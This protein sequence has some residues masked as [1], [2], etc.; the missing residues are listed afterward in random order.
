MSEPPVEHG[1][2]HQAC[3]SLPQRA[4]RAHHA[5]GCGGRGGPVRKLPSYSGIAPALRLTPA[6][7]N[8]CRPRFMWV[9]WL[10]R[11]PPPTLVSC[12][13]FCAYLCIMCTVRKTRDPAAQHHRQHV[14]PRFLGACPRF[15]G[16]HTVC[17]SSALCP[18]V[19]EQ[20]LEYSLREG[21]ADAPHEAQWELVACNPMPV[22]K[23]SLLLSPSA[24]CL[25]LGSACA[26]Q[27]HGSSQQQQV[28]QQEQQGQQQQPEEVQEVR[29]EAEVALP[30]GAVLVD[31]ANAGHDHFSIVARVRGCFCTVQQLQQPPGGAPQPAP[32]RLQLSVR[33][34]ASLLREVCAARGLA[35]QAPPPAVLCLE[36][37]HGNRSCVASSTAVLW[38]PQS[39]Q[40]VAQLRDWVLQVCLT[41]AY[42]AAHQASCVQLPVRLVPPLVLS[43]SRSARG[44]LL[45]PS[46]GTTCCPCYQCRDMRRSNV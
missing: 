3:A 33:L 20:V 44:G 12:M 15:L 35:G 40:A 1:W 24:L 7:P 17:A 2:G 9:R 32:R 19:N 14:C 43:A 6:A 34:P 37:W 38:P 45:V 8:A 42:C 28:Q 46:L 13:C 22:R 39:Q 27:G 21:G 16:V 18:Q 30:A 23:C 25:C 26:A 36:V 10:Q 29:I 5:A 41:D 11:P 31:H 4:G